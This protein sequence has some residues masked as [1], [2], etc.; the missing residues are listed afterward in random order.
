MTPDLWNTR[1]RTTV[2]AVE[3]IALALAIFVTIAR[4]GTDP[5]VFIAAV[6]GSIWVIGTTRI[7]LDVASR[8]FVLDAIGL[9]G[10]ALTMTALVLTGGVD[11]PYLL[12]SLTPSIYA[13][14][15]GGIRLGLAVGALTAL[16]AVATRLAGDS[17]IVDA[18]PLAVLALALGVTVAQIRRIF[19]E[20]DSRVTA[21]EASTDASIVRLQH[22][23][24]AN[25]LL[26]RLAEIT[27]RDEV[28]P[29]AV[30]RAALEAI[31]SRFP[32]SSGSAALESDNGPILV[33]RYGTL[34][35]PHFDNEIPLYVS[36]KRV[37]FIRLSTPEPLDEGT[38]VGLHEALRPVSLAF[39]NALLL[40][41]VTKNAV[42]EERTRLARE[43]HDE[44]GPS[45]ASLGLSLDMALIQGVDQREMNDH[46]SVL[47]DRVAGLVDEVRST[48]TD[49]RSGSAISLVT[50]VEDLRSTLTTSMTVS[51]DV[52]ERRPVRPSLADDVYGII[53][54]ALR[55]A[56]S[57]SS[58]DTVTI[59][60]WVDFDRGRVV[61]SD[62][63]TG[64]DPQESRTGH[65]GLVGMR[66]RAS[67]STLRLDI[68]SGALGT[69]VTIEW[70][71]T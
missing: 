49:L 52:D 62:N 16:L 8:P 20:L 63:G 29:I 18:T 22:L 60:G 58:G 6:L 46:L 34:P 65:F 10:V 30:G 44:I 5:L 36:E 28:N 27:S 11:S 39:A 56:V 48:V 12:L 50:R 70:D 9:V 2:I 71:G 55:N 51:V 47:R 1:L 42:R 40:Q 23:E 15:F 57:H 61:V 43:L 33:S 67:N 21:A 64:F 35:D 3:W 66:E 45:L 69:D 7:P 32:G 38:L 37:G 68:S 26:A 13:G 54:E 14:M 31:T 19:L 25:Q 17:S 4:L 53:G 24:S 59:K 41:D